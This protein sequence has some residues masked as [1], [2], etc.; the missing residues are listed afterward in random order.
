MAEIQIKQDKLLNLLQELIRINSTNPS[1]SPEGK[2]EHEIAHYLREYLA[3]LGL[4]THI[5]NVGKNRAN[6]IGVY[7]GSGGGKSVLLCG[8][9]DTVSINRMEIDPFEPEFVDGKV[10]GRGALDMKSGVAALILAVQSI[11][12]A[13]KKLK[14]DVYLVLVAD[15]EYASIGMESVL[16]KY[17]ADGAILCE[18]TNQEIVIAHKGFSWIKV[19]IFG[20]S[21]HGSRPD[22]G[23]DAIVKSGK[24]LKEIENLGNN[25][26]IQK[27]H[28]LLGFPSIHASSINGGIELSTYPDYCKIELERRNL[29][30]EEP[31]DVANEIDRILSDIKSKDAQFKADYE[32]FFSRPAFEI[33]KEEPIVQ[34]IVRAHSAAGM[35]MPKFK[36]LGGW[37]ESALLFEAGIPPVIFGPSGSGAHAAVE[38]VNFD[39][40]VSTTEVLIKTLID[41]CDPHFP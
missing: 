34:S 4:E 30:G 16:E 32:I 15:E 24:V 5:Q 40:V 29:P 25:V 37:M 35:G 17:S 8:H 3:R 6:I 22:K 19:E 23:I 13:G 36:G 39:S 38:Y 10:Y 14:G 9:I 33:S 2:G 1:L 41:F 26:L 28:P 11:V 31:A 18:P 12:E 20:C 27:K 7:K 21:A